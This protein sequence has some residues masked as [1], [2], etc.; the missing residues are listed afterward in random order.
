[1][2]GDVRKKRITL[3]ITEQTAERFVKRT[4]QSGITQSFVAE[5]LIKGWLNK[6]LDCGVSM[7]DNVN[8]K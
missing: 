2:K 1:M 7:P 8:S 3:Y 5:S 6:P 4:N